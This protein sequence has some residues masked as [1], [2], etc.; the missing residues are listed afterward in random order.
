MDNTNLH[1]N[2]AEQGKVFA[3]QGNHKEALR[4]YKEALR[5][6]QQIPQ[7]D[8]F[9]QHYSQCAMESLEQM[10]SYLEVITFCDK[11][12]AFMESKEDLQA[13]PVFMKYLA[14]LWERKGIQYLYLNDK[15]DAITAFEKAIAIQKPSKI[16]LAQELHNWC[17]RG[18]TISQQQIEGLNKKHHY[19]IV[20]KDTINSKI[21]I[22]LPEMIN[23]L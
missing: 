9:F 11:C 19:Y 20:R 3:T 21:A 22:E 16:P 10:K 12:I 17:K 4:H 13:H 7:A 14:S 23:P 15:E 5:M 1:Y 2:I 18:Y 6:S 8:I